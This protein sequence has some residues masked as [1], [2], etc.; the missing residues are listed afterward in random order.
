MEANPGRH[1]ANVWA[2]QSIWQCDLYLHRWKIL[3]CQVIVFTYYNLLLFVE[4]F[5]TD[6]GEALH[7]LWRAVLGKP[8]VARHG[9]PV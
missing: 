7:E 9:I 8:T 3:A 6:K 5:C 4:E 1:V 2:F